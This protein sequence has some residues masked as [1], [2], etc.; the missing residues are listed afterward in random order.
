MMEKKDRALLKMD[1]AG[2][3][4]GG[5]ACRPMEVQQVDRRE[6]RVPARRRLLKSLHCPDVVLLFH[7]SSQLGL[8]HLTGTQLLSFLTYLGHLASS[9]AVETDEIWMDWLLL[10]LFFIF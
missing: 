7:F 1:A 6:P 8:I 10:F 9:Y 3:G 2:G 5:G 4:G